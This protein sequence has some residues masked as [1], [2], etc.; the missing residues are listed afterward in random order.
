ME[1][2]MTTIHADVRVYGDRSRTH[3][4]GWLRKGD[5]VNIEN[6]YKNWRRFVPTFGCADLLE[7]TDSYSVYFFNVLDFEG[8]DVIDPEEPAPDPDEQVPGPFIPEPVPSWPSDTELGAAVRVIAS[9]FAA[10]LR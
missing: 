1:N 9:Y 6:F 10:V 2:R 3:K 5:V 7:L 4:L 8:A